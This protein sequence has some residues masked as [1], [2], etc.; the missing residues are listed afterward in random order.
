ML[1]IYLEQ[2]KLAYLQN[3]DVLF[4]QTLSSITKILGSGLWSPQIMS[5]I[6]QQISWLTSVEFKN[7]SLL[8]QAILNLEDQLK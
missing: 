7:Y 4:K 2:A 3:N 6:K 8:L 1:H 5:E